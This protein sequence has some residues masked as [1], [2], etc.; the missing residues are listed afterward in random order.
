MSPRSGLPRISA[1]IL[2]SLGQHRVRIQ[3]SVGRQV[4]AKKTPILSFKPDDVI[5]AAE[6]IEQ[7]VGPLPKGPIDPLKPE[8]HRGL[9]G[10]SDGPGGSEG[11]GCAHCG[12]SD[13]EIAAGLGTTTTFALFGLFG[14]RR[15]R[16]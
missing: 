14:L 15:R 16:E 5:R 3:G 9:R 10:G 4:R 13:E 6:R 11:G 7:D 12:S 2:A 8:K 1:E